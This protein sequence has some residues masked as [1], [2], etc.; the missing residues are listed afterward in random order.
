MSWLYVVASV[1]LKPATKRKI[2]SDIATIGGAALPAGVYDEALESGL[3]KTGTSYNT[4]RPFQL[5][6]LIRFAHKWLLLDK[7]ERQG[8]LGDEFVEA[9]ESA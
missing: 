1:N 4:H 9:Y 3:A 2:L 5:W 6:F 7:A 8:L